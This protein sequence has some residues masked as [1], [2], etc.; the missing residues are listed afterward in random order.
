MVLIGDIP[1]DIIAKKYERTNIYTLD[2]NLDEYFRDVLQDTSPDTP[3]LESD[4]KRTNHESAGRLSL[5]YNGK[6]SEMEP[7]HSEEFLGFTDRDPRGTATEP[8]MRKYQEQMWKRKKIIESLMHS[9]A[10]NSVPSDGINELKMIKNIRKGFYNLK[11]RLKIFDTSKEN[12]LHGYNQLR[13]NNNSKVD[14]I[15][16]DQVISTLPDT[17]NPI[18][19]LDYTTLKSL[20]I[21]VGWGQQADHIFKVAQYGKPNAKQLGKT[22]FRNNLDMMEKDN[23]ILEIFKHDGNIVP[24]HLM[25][26]IEKLKND[27]I[28]KLNVGSLTTELKNSESMQNR[29]INKNVIIDKNNELLTT[30]QSHKNNNKLVDLLTILFQQYSK[31]YDIRNNKTLMDITVNDINKAE[32]I[33]RKL[34]NKLDLYDI[35]KKTIETR[36]IKTHTKGNNKENISNNYKHLNPKLIQKN[37]VVKYNNTNLDGVKDNHSKL[38]YYKIP[39]TKNKQNDAKNIMEGFEMRNILSKLDNITHQDRAQNVVSKK[40]LDKNHFNY[41]EYFG[42]N[43]YIE[44]H[45]APMGKKYMAKFVDY[46]HDKNDLNDN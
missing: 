24:K 1:D 10:D 20:T 25:I 46:D 37:N 44:K 42:E 18:R 41:E 38:H 34:Q 43:K 6:R 28:N 45:T 7:N 9:D 17:R 33:N 30:E 2:D 19:R 14:F 27:K 8:D 4:Q 26:T 12:L 39:I 13:I 11:D 32:G 23:K 16:H 5:R 29:K 40:V 35:M 22:D 15:Q 3:Y 21:P 31:D 36:D